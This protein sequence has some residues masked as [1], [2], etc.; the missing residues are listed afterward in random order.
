MNVIRDID[1]KVAIG[2]SMFNFLKLLCRS[3]IYRGKWCFVNYKIF[4]NTQGSIGTS[5]VTVSETL[6]TRDDTVTSMTPCFGW[7]WVYVLPK[8]FMFG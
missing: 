6:N 3:H 2:T 5:I 4:P 7:H 8:I 1:P